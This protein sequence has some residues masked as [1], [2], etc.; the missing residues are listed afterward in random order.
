[1]GVLKIDKKEIDVNNSRKQDIESSFYYAL[2]H[3]IRRKI[4]KLIGDN[5]YTSFTNLK[6][7]LKVST[8]TIYHHL[9]TLSELIE[10]QANKKYYLTELG[11]YAY[12]SLKDNI[13]TMTSTD[14]E[15]K[16]PILKKLTHITLKRFIVFDKKDKKYSILLSIS[17]IIAGTILCGLNEFYAFLFFFMDFNHRELETIIEF[18]IRISFILNFIILFFII[19][20]IT[21]IFYKKKESSMN[22]FISFAIILFPL[23]FYLSIHLIF[24][25]TN[26]VGISI[27]NFIDK[28]FMVFFQVWSLWLLSY[29]LS[30]NKGLKIERSLIISLLLHYG[31]FTIILFFLV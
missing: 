4:I 22:F 13:E 11:I 5:E 24:K 14:S 19:E 31:G 16:S 23:I 28:I 12:N 29:S 27:F 1:L 2:S 10:K 25:F 17:I 15:F 18:L 8:G 21:R 6:K 26:L 20:G 7:E 30:V 9:D 3:E